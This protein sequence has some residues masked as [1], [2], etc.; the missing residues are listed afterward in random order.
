M[1]VLVFSSLKGGVGKTTAALF[2]AEALAHAGHRVIA[3]DADANNNLTDALAREESPETLEAHSLYRALTRRRPLAECV[4]PAAFNLGLVPGTP[5]L[6]RAGAELVRD[7]GV[8]LRFPMELKAL[9]AEVIVIDTAPALTIELT[10]ALYCA[11]V[12]IVPVMLSRWSAA[13]Y[14]VIADEVHAVQEATGRPVR[15][16]A[17]PDIVTERENETLRKADGWTMTRTSIFK[18]AAIRNAA[19]NGRALRD[20]GKAWTWYEL[21]AREVME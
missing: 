15:I 1:K 20:T 9:D 11:D 17:L 18:S 8:V 2:T 6:A 5:S 14:R 3:I 13:A 16:L 10:L 19:N 4:I 12:V 7:P 21:L